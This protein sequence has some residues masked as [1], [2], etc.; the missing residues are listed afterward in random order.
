METEFGYKQNPVNTI[1]MAHKSIMKENLKELKELLSK[2]ALCLY[3]TSNGLAHLKKEL[4]PKINKYS[5]EANL[6]I[7]KYLKNARFVGFWSYYTEEYKLSLINKD[8]KNLEAEI[9]VG[10]NF[11]FDRVRSKSDLDRPVNEYEIKTCRIQ[12]LT[13]HA[14]AAI[15]MT[16]ACKDFEVQPL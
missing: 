8:K 15:P 9:I 6:L 12:K 1:V 4:L 13:G 16:K 14:I 2:E 3:G 5:L 11:G 10:C 7:S